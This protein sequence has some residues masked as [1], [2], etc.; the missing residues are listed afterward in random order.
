MAAMKRLL[1][2]IAGT[3]VVFGLSA[4]DGKA[5]EADAE[6]GAMSS[7]Y[8]AGA[9]A[10]A[11][12]RCIANFPKAAGCCITIMH[13][14][15]FPNADTTAGCQEACKMLKTASPEMVAK[16]IE[17]SHDPADLQRFVCH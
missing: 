7:P 14:C 3:L 9:P 1:I 12:D 10:K 11:A 15:Q 4:C 5:K 6:C 2:V 16:R 8:A 13:I 17:G